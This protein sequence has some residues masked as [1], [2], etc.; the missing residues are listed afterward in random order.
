MFFDTHAHFDDFEADE[1]TDSVLARAR[2]AGVLQML[3]VGGNPEA[4]HRAVALCGRYP[5]RLWAAVGLDRD[6]AEMAPDGGDTALL[7]REGAW[8]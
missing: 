5:E 7:A 3:A 8:R 1:T 2:D 4:N 6:Q